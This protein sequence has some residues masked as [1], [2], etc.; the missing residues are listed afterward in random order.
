MLRV[1][2]GGGG[3]VRSI[4]D[5]FF[6]EKT[7]YEI[8]PSLVGSERYIRDRCQEAIARQTQAS[9]VR[10]ETYKKANLLAHEQKQVQ[11]AI[12]DK[13]GSESKSAGD[14]QT[15]E[16]Q[17]AK[18]MGDCLL[19]KSDAADDLTRRHPAVARIHHTT[20]YAPSGT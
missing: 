7:A 11:Q 18:W 15:T 10:M 3:A 4:A 19:S 9:E 17:K 14:D 13:R 6:K 5:F 20:T 8:M 2:F 16:I 12:L 1:W